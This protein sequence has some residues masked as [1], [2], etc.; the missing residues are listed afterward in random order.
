MLNMKTLWKMFAMNVHLAKLL[1]VARFDDAL[2]LSFQV[3]M[4]RCAHIHVYCYR[5][6]HGCNGCTT[7][8]LKKTSPTFSTVT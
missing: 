7:V 2:V 8:C 4:H 6:F 1:N 3:F 5:V